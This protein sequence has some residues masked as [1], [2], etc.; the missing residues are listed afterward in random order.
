[1]RFHLLLYETGFVPHRMK[2]GRKS[3]SWNVL[4]YFTVV[5]DQTVSLAYVTSLR[6]EGKQTHILCKSKTLSTQEMR[7]R[8][9]KYCRWEIMFLY[10]QYMLPYLLPLPTPLIPLRFASY[11]RGTHRLVL[12]TVR[13]CLCLSAKVMR[14]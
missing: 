12:T 14:R 1:V 9:R 7:Q 10:E 4:G 11:G 2:T 13:S 3:N 8:T 6:V 5:G